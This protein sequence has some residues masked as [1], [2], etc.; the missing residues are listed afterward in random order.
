MQL[1]V[2]LLVYFFIFFYFLCM[3]GNSFELNE[4]FFFY[5]WWCFNWGFFFFIILILILFLWV[6]IVVEFWVMGSH[7]YL[8]LILL[9][10]EFWK[11][12][13]VV[14]F[15]VYASTCSLGANYDESSKLINFWKSYYIVSF[16]RYWQWLVSS[17]WNH[18]LN[19][20]EFMMNLQKLLVIVK[21]STMESDSKHF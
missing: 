2:F 15:L 18:L 11:I 6:L 16:E 10:T 17:C 3:I 13:A 8:G 19:L 14:G 7:A 12:L 1:I 21:F 9:Y 5:W 4:I 20:R